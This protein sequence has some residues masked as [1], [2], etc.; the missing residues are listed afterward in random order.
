MG[1]GWNYRVLKRTY[2]LPNGESEIDYAIYEVYYNVN[3]EPNA[4]SKN[5]MYIRGDSIE[6][7]K[8]DLELYKQAFNKPILDYHSLSVLHF[9]TQTQED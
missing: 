2:P 3:G 5:P 8:A 6:E 1:M 9:L 4:C 7:L